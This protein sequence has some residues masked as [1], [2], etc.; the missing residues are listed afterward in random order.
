MLNKRGKKPCVPKSSKWSRKV[1]TIR[2]IPSVTKS[3]DKAMNITF[4]NIKSR[5]N[6][7][8]EIR[9]KLPPMTRTRYSIQKSLFSCRWLRTIS[10]VSQRKTKIKISESDL[11]SSASVCLSWNLQ[12]RGM[13]R[14]LAQK[15]TLINFNFLF[16]MIQSFENTFFK[17]VLT[18]LWL[19]N[20]CINLLNN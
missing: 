7:K 5:R 12:N 15:I 6:K 2:R 8:I 18:N 3:L 4:S 11:F 10:V 17:D 16:L 14:F 19:H 13:S 9:N 20:P 1:L